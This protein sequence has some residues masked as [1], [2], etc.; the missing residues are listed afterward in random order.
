MIGD[1]PAI[2]RKNHPENVSG[3]SPGSRITACDGDREG[4][5][6]DEAVTHVEH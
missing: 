2:K 1:L 3:V 4:K 6:G 5:Y